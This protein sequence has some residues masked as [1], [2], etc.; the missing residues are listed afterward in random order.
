M[1][2]ARAP[3]AGIAVAALVVVASISA[4]ST[5]TPTLT[6]K[7]PRAGNAFSKAKSPWINVSGTAGFATPTPLSEKFYLRRDGC[8]T[9]NDNPT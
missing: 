3:V 6:L 7:T 5:S 9:T 8:G 1:A 4:A 2:R